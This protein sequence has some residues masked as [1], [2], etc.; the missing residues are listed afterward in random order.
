MHTTAQALKCLQICYDLTTMYRSIDLVT[1]DKRTGDVV[2]L[3][4]QDI[5]IQI[6]PSGACD[7]VRVISLILHRCRAVSFECT[8]L[9]IEKTRRRCKPLWI[10]GVLRI[11]IHE[12]ISQG[13]TSKRRSQ[14]FLSHFESLRQKNQL[15]GDR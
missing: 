8:S 6:K 7:F 2:I 13:M 9:I 4:G 5:N 3:S 12:C 14:S 11:Q 10:S 15:E 1:F